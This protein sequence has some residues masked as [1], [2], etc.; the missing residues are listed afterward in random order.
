MIQVREVVNGIPA[1]IVAALGTEKVVREGGT[2]K[3]SEKPDDP[4]P[5]PSQTYTPAPTRR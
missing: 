3:P 1:E 4:T 5:I 2:M